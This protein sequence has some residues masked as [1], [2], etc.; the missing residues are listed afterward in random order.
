M[1]LPN[2]AASHHMCPLLCDK[3]LWFAIK[4][5]RTPW[6]TTHQY[7]QRHCRL[8]APSANP[9]LIRFFH[10][11]AVGSATRRRRQYKPT[12]S[13]LG[14]DE[15][16]RCMLFVAPLRCKRLRAAY[17]KRWHTSCLPHCGS[18]LTPAANVSSLM[19][20]VKRDGFVIQCLP[21][22]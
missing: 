3:R 4:R 19:V 9:I 7:L 15:C 5:M 6:F 12:T 16:T 21:F 14:R 18:F 17:Y 22:L 11:A 1:F 2:A 13:L 20:N 10:R 8:L